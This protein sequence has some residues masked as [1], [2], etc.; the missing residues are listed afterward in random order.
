MTWT[1]TCTD[2]PATVLAL[3]QTNLASTSDPV[4]TAVHKTARAM[5]Q[6]LG[7]AARVTLQC[8]GVSTET[9]SRVQISVGVA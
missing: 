7:G 3:I 6:A 5:V 8:E 9:G 2:I 4:Q 1:M